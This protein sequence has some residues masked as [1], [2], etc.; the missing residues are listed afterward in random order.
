MSEFLQTP[1][2]LLTFNRP[3]T[4]LKVFEKIKQVKPL[5]LYIACDGPRDG[6][7]S[8][9][10]EISKIKEI[11]IKVNWPC[12]VKTLFREKNL[13]LKQAVSSAITWFFEHEEQG[14]IL[15]DDCLPSTT[16]FRFCE[17]L[18]NLYKNNE[19]I[20]MISGYNRQEQWKIKENDY[21]FSYLG[22]CWGWATWRR[23]WNYFD[24]D[25]K[26][27]EHMIKDNIFENQMG[28]KLGSIRQKELLNFKKVS[29]KIESWAYPW[30]LT[31]HK[32]NAL[33]C[34]PNRNMIQNI[35][36]NDSATNTKKI[37]LKKLKKY[38]IKFPLKVNKDV[39]GDYRYDLLFL[40][41]GFLLKR[42]IN[43][44]LNIIKKYL[45]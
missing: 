7:I 27:L 15:E 43:K 24:P 19:K 12:K 33:C 20:F 2:L 36:F 35:G 28:K 18:L 5:K 25:M 23:A 14:I 13:G 3:I 21:F 1:I 9:I 17:E 45:P 37:Q 4:T 16:F 22:G 31:R 38:E 30:G 6:N 11:I 10:E 44:I 32:F 26:D 29:D 41:K 39:K 8:D 40:N 34:I 42:I